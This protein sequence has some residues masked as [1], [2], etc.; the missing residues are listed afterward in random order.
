MINPE[1]ARPGES[2]AIDS[3]ASFAAAVQWAV[4]LADARGARTLL[5]VDPDF[6]A[7]PLDEQVLLD[8]LAHWLARPMRRLVLLAD[9]FDAVEARHARFAAWRAMRA[10]AVD[11][12]VPAEG[13]RIELPTLL[14][15]DGP[16][17]LHLVDAVHWRGRAAHDAAQARAWRDRL[18]AC[19]QRSAPAWPVRPLGL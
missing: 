2:L 10:H 11:T 19:V 4:S 15:D 7:W 5:M 3:R 8:V 12:R 9:S 16:V 6:A 1:E 18:D 17:I 13:E 14:L